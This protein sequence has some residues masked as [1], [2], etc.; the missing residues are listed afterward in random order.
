V[1]H[2]LGWLSRVTVFGCTPAMTKNMVFLNY[3]FCVFCPFF[4][5]SIN[6]GCINKIPLNPP[7]QKGEAVGMP[8][9]IEMLPFFDCSEINF[10]Q[11]RFTKKLFFCFLHQFIHKFFKRQKALRRA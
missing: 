11:N 9:L 4:R 8:G 1:G 2:I 10:N 5:N 7:L 3:S 6:S